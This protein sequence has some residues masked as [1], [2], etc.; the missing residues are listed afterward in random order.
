LERITIKTAWRLP[1]SKR[2]GAHHHQNCLAFTANKTAW[3][4]SPSK[5]PGVYRHQ[6][7]LAFTAINL[8]NFIVFVYNEAHIDEGG[9]LHDVIVL[10][11]GR[12]TEGWVLGLY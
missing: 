1:P 5:L 10:L 2:P 8:F 6:S 7:Y 3:S 9:P 12:Q 4:A 11:W